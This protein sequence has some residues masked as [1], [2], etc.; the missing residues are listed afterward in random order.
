MYYLH[1]PPIASIES[2]MVYNRTYTL[3]K[4]LKHNVM[5]KCNLIVNCIILYV[6]NKVKNVGYTCT[7]IWLININLI[8]LIHSNNCLQYLSSVKYSLNTNRHSLRGKSTNK[9]SSTKLWWP[10][11]KDERLGCC[12]ERKVSVL[13]TLD[14]GHI[15]R[16]I[17]IHLWRIKFSQPHSGIK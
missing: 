7:D 14:D 10:L 6:A 11:Q 5:L 2:W 13:F 15:N 1:S 3:H 16:W 12:C 9:M 4:I 8:H 17:G